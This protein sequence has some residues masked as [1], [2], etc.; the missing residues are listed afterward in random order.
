[1]IILCLLGVIVSM[2][3]IWRA[4]DAFEDSSEFLGRN[5]SE[6]V[7]GATI[8]AIGSSLPELLATSLALLFYANTEGFA[9]GIGTTAGSAIFNSAIIPGLVILMVTLTGVTAAVVVSRKVILRDGLFLLGAEALLIYLLS[10]GTVSWVHG[11]VLI[12]FYLVYITYMLTSM[13]KTDP[14]KEEEEEEPDESGILPSICWSFFTLDLTSLLL[15]GKEITTSR[16]WILIGSATLVIAFACWILVEACYGLGSALGIRTYFIAVILAAAATSVPD[17]ILSL[18]DAK[19]GNYDDAV[20]NALGSNIFDICICLGLP[21]FLYCIFTGNTISLGIE[22]Q[23]SI[24][25]LRVLLFLLTGLLVFIFLSNPL[26]KLDG[27][28]MLG[29]YAV[30]VIYIIAR[31]F[32]VPLALTIGHGFQ[33]VLKFIGG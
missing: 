24:A 13:K 28:V 27:F 10:K 22:D 32:E 29:I 19:K 16:A 5:L 6:G 20:A 26:S 8:N 11:L 23:G 14:G 17:T 12:G 25:E 18:K 7:R 31:V 2:L 15:R 1:M 4:C 33:N 21:L 9:F 30:F 3:I